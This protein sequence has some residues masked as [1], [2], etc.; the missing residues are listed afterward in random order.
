MQLSWN[1]G[2]LA[3][4]CSARTLG[5]EW[6]PGSPG[7]HPNPELCSGRDPAQACEGQW[8]FRG[9]FPTMLVS[10]TLAHILLHVQILNF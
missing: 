5:M 3:T 1:L 9:S 4:G 10:P 7:G 8:G 6:K 2:S